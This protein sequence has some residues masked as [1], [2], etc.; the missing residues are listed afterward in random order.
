MPLLL[1][2]VML[3]ALGAISITGYELGR[4][5]RQAGQAALARV[6]A[7][8]AA[9]AALAQALA[10]WPPG[11]TPV[12]AGEETFLVSF[13]G[14]AGTRGTATVRA[15]GGPVY[16]LRAE[17]EKRD[18]AGSAIGFAELELLVLLDSA[19]P[20]STV[21]PRRYPRGLRILP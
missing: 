16:A 19:G 18:Q 12:A 21:R 8:G 17:G 1:A 15:L 9:E 10:G 3:T 4:S 6:Q 7:R 13:M 5:E 11:L 2:I 20:D 14:P